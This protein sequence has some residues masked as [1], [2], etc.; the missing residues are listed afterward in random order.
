MPQQLRPEYLGA[1]VMDG[2]LEPGRSGVLRL[3]ACPRLSV[4]Q[5][6]GDDSSLTL[7]AEGARTLWCAFYTPDVVNNRWEPY[8]QPGAAAYI[9]LPF[10][11]LDQIAVAGGVLL[12]Q[13]APCDASLR[14]VLPRGNSHFLEVLSTAGI[15]ELQLALQVFLAELAIPRAAQLK[16]AGHVLKRSAPL[17]EALNLFVAA[18]PS[19]LPAPA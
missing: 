10:K 13:R 1:F 12:L 8:D 5:E 4:K 7:I 18:P 19:P 15:S 3:S 17:F 9:P 2:A 6:P 14:A 11:A 16:C